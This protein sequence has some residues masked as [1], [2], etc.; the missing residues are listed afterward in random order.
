MRKA[1]KYLLVFILIILMSI[2]YGC[3][4]GINDLGE[5]DDTV[6]NNHGLDFLD[7]LN[8][9]DVYTRLFNE[10]HFMSTD[11][12]LDYE[13]AEKQAFKVLNL[14]SLADI[15]TES[16]SM[17]KDQLSTQS[18]LYQKIKAINLYLSLMGRNYSPD[19]LRDRISEAVQLCSK[20]LDYYKV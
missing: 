5:L 8:P 6:G 12:I 16:T 11:C 13:L 15:A 20:M 17:T 18:K 7:L 1:K 10:L 2:L 14:Y 19:Y 9:K 3:D 4:P